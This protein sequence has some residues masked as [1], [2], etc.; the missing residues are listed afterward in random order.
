M[1][2]ITDFSTDVNKVRL[3]IGDIDNSDQIFN[4][5]A[6]QAFIDLA[7]DSNVKRAAAQALLTIAVNEVLVQ[8]RITLLDLK[9]DGP[10]EADALR[11]LAKALADQADNEEITDA[12]DYAEMVG[13]P[14]Q[15][16]QRIN[17]EYLRNGA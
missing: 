14:F 15:W 9:T 10:A 7:L 4:D 11:Q 2:A 12:F 16:R 5:S 6:I 17:N 13:D 8:K 3:L 1:A